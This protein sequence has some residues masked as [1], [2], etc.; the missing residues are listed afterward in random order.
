MSIM[1][2]W[3][4]DISTWITSYVILDAISDNIASS[5]HAEK[6]IHTVLK[7]LIILR[8]RCIYINIS[9]FMHCD[10]TCAQMLIIVEYVEV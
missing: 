9:C 1:D 4:S 10:L 8:L 7:V 2:V 5:W 6:V 3:G